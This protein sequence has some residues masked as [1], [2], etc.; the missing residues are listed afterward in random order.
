M[1]HRPVGRD[2]AALPGPPGYCSAQLIPYLGNKRALL[3]RLY[4]VFKRLT[5]GRVGP[6]SFADAF[7]G[8]GA[9]SRLARAMGLRVASNDWEPYS[10]AIGHCWLSLSPTDLDA[11]FGGGQGL[12]S[13]LDDW[14][15]MHPMSG[16]PYGG[17]AEPYIARWYAPERTDAPRLGEERLF[18]T[19]ENATFIDRVRERVESEYPS[20]EPLSPGDVRRRVAMGALL[21]EA[22]VHTNT[23]GVFKAYHRGFGGHGKDA[24]GRILGRM[25]FEAP[26]L[27]DAPPAEVYGL[28]AAAFM[29]GKSFDI[30]Y[31][32]PPYNQHQ[33]GP[34]YHLLNTILVWDREPR[35]LASSERHSTKAGIPVDWKERRSPFCVRREAA[36]AI[37]SL[38]DATDAGSIV[39]SWNADGHLSGED[40][41]ALLAPRGRL[42]IIAL[43]YIAYRGGRQSAS[44]SERSREYLFVVDTR[45]EATD[46]D[47]A[48]RSLADLAAVDEALRSSYDPERVRSVFFGSE[49]PWLE[50]AAF[51]GG[52]MRRAADD[53]GQLLRAMPDDRRGPFCEALA[54]C[55]CS[56]VSDDLDAL[57]ATGNA[58]IGAGDRRAAR[59]AGSK[60]LRYVRKL[61]HEKYADEFRRYLGAF[62]AMAEACGDEATSVGLVEL[63]QL[64]ERRKH[65][66]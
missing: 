49:A 4:P 14:N 57:L 23:S 5:S 6:L 11:A 25:E 65:G 9:V 18:Y 19:A 30:A 21:L 61:A 52:G 16:V 62:A 48:R 63:A 7:A 51:F 53:A 3:P 56:S 44:R 20:P 8:S 41:A 60:A 27:P 64:V 12:A 54:A 29:A 1:S 50:A 24:L 66:D 35:P 32:D 34:N 55:A 47:L 59:I 31:F 33:Y 28:D 39:F 22:A 10:Q 43:D 17:A 36:G 13:F 45:A 26:V 37:R 15:S 42:E 2:A 40:M 46:E 58:A 38:L